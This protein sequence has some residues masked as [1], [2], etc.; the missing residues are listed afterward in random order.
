MRQKTKNIIGWALTALV[1]LVFIASAFMKLTGGE[2]LANNAASMGLTANSIKLIGVIELLCI[3]VFIVPR[4]GVLGIL[5]VAAYLGGAIITHV[6]H[7]QPFFIPV[8]VQALAWIAALIRF[9]ELGK[10]LAG[11][12][13]V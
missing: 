11:K 9:P 1:A 4:T 3:I 10:R 5:L 6:E 13:T 7:N 8:V 2:E 12:A